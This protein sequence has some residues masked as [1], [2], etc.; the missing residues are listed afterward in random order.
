MISHSSARPRG[1]FPSAR[2][3]SDHPPD[4]R[5]TPA[6]EN[7]E[8]D[9]HYA[10]DLLADEKE[11]AEHLM[12]VDLARNDIGRVS[13]MGSVSVEDF[14]TIERYSHVIHIVSQTIGK[15]AA[16]KMPTT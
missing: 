5:H 11:R 3:A 15:I 1:A 9:A 8:E 7:R 10:E 14:M 12:L 4:R 6:R 13:Q 16:E 2:R